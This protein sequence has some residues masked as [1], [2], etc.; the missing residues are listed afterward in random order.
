MSTKLRNRYGWAFSTSAR[1]SDAGTFA[2]KKSSQP[3]PRARHVPRRGAGRIDESG[4]VGDG[5][6]RIIEYAVHMRRLPEDRM[7]DCLIACDAVEPRDIDPLIRL[8]A[9]FHS[10]AATGPGVNEHAS[11]ESVRAAMIRNLDECRA[12]ADADRFPW[13]V[14]SDS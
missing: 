2:R 12:V 10:R 6:G 9:D 5:P 14:L 13:S 7:L 4:A 8:L 3:P 1:W 11:P